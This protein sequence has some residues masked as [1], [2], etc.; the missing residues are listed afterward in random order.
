MGTESGFCPVAHISLPR[1]N[2]GFGEPKMRGEAMKDA[3]VTL[4]LVKYVLTSVYVGRDDRHQ[5]REYQ[6]VHAARGAGLM[7]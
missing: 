4:G 3:L 7:K 6:K 1:T 5:V 2:L